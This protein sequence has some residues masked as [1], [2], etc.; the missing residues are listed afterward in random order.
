AIVLSLLNGISCIVPV[1][2]RVVGHLI[3]LRFPWQSLFY[4]MSEMGII[5]GMLSLFILRETRPARLAPRD[6]SRSTTSAESLV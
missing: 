2:A 6:L 4:T 5:V 1:L 3:M